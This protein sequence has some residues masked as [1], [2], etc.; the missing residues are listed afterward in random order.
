[1]GIGVVR[2]RIDMK[3]EVRD[4]DGKRKKEKSGQYLF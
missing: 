2:Y 3:Y 1:M 4:E